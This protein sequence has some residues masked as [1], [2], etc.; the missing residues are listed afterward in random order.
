MKARIGTR[1]GVGQL[2]RASGYFWSIR[3]ISEKGD[4]QYSYQICSTGPY[5]TEK[6]A[7]RAA[8]RVARQFNLEC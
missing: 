4:E 5:V 6:G 1:F 8:R 7:R 3:V 2:T